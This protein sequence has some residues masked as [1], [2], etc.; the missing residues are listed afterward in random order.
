MG[1]RACGKRSQRGRVQ[2]TAENVRRG[3]SSYFGDVESALGSGQAVRS[4]RALTRPLLRQPGASAAGVLF[5]PGARSL[6]LRHEVDNEHVIDER[7]DQF[8]ESLVFRVFQVSVAFFLGFERED[9]TVRKT[10]VALFLA[11][12][13]APF[14]GFYS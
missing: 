2:A 9:E 10:F 3:Q 8:A 11:D 13:C 1:S 12:I 6:L 14:K 7:S 5:A 4:Q